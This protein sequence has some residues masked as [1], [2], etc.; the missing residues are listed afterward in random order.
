MPLFEVS[1]CFCTPGKTW[2][3]DTSRD[4][5]AVIDARNGVLAAKTALDELEYDERADL[6]HFIHV[7]HP[8]LPP[9]QRR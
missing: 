3:E 6:V 4:I 8:R 9:D 5:T 2:H 1:I 7:G